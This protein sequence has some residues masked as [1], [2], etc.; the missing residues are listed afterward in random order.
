MGRDT[1]SYFT[2]Y[3]ELLETKR[4]N[5]VKN[6]SSAFRRNDPPSI[7]R[8]V[9]SVINSPRVAF[10][11]YFVAGQDDA[12]LGTLLGQQV[13]RKGERISLL[14][15]SYPSFATSFY[16]NAFLSLIISSAALVSRDAGIGQSDPIGFCVNFLPDLK[17]YQKCEKTLIKIHRIFP[18]MENSFF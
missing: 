13:C 16:R 4:A 1:R 3:L 10:A 2:K 14:F 11:R 17:I 15:S 9:W 5:C 7:G 8:G 18:S 12:L 6:C